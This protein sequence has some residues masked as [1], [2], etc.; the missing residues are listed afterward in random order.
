MLLQLTLKGIFW[1]F[2][3]VFG[4]FRAA[5]M[6]YRGTQARGLIGAVTGGLRHSHTGSKPR[7]RPT[8]QLMSRPDP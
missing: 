8:L 2:W 3:F 1:V 6:A 5:P 4:L 7:L